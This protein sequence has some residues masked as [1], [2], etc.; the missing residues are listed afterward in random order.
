M[1][2]K[3]LNI[4]YPIIQGAMANIATPKFAASVS[5]SGGLGIIATGAMNPDEVREAICLCKTLTDKPFGVNVMLMNPYSEEI[6]NVIVQ[7]KVDVVTTGAGNPG[8]YIDM[9]KESGCKVIPVVPTVALARRMENAGVDAVI[10][11]GTEAGGHVGDITTMALVPQV[12]DA[13]KIPVI[14]AGGI[15]D[16]RGFI[17]ALSLGA[18]GV[19]IGTCL[20]VSEECEVHENY[21]E[22]ILKA[23]DS[24]TIVTGRSAKVPVR[25]LKNK[26]SREYL[27]LEA[28]KATKE[29]LEALTLGSMKKAVFNGDVDNGS[30]MT[31][32]IAGLCNKRQTIQEILDDMVMSSFDILNSLSNLSSEFKNIGEN[33]E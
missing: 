7:E 3:L 30:V 10:V 14:A 22:A 11:E 29:E 13:V 6:M 31:G 15:G 28:N 19:Q 21:K 4:K 5:N 26:M 23:K 12:V 25:I 16:S 33:Y 27:K 2:N 9:L 20:L 18:R 24:D 32:Q 1:I 8:K 17:A